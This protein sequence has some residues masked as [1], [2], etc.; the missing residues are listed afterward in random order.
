MLRSITMVDS[1]IT[2]S[3]K[4]IWI[5]WMRDLDLTPKF[6]SAWWSEEAASNQCAKLQK[7]DL[8]ILYFVTKEEVQ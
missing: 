2:N 3:I 6:C 1:E 4:P 8:E 5:V 7:C